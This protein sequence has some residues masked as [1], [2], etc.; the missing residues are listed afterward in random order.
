MARLPTSF[1]FAYVLV[2]SLVLLGCN[3]SSDSDG[4]STGTLE[5]HLTDHREAIG[6]F[7]R[8]DVEIDTVRLHPKRLLSLGKSDWLD[9][10]PAVASADLTR[11][12]NRRTL[13][14]WTGELPS[15]RFEALH[16]KLKG[17]GGELKASA[18]AAPVAD[19]AGPIRLPFE[20]KTGETTRIVVDLVVLDMSDH[21]NR[22]YEVHVR[23]YE[24]YYNGALAD[25][26]PPG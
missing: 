15:G 19:E 5:I 1:F 2:L 12:T 3:A 8:L 13:S 14:I 11:Y 10:Q 21:P 20:V 24:L 9:L 17:A 26:V 6:D 7:A 18:E 16:L 4:V 23:G 22:G 25:K